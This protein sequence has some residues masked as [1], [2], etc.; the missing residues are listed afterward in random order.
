[1][2][3][4][5]PRTVYAVLGALLLF[6]FYHMTSGGEPKP[7]Q[8]GPFSGQVVD[9]ATGMPIPGAVLVVVWIREIPTPIHAGEQFFDARVGVAD[10]TGHFEIPPHPRPWF[11]G[12]SVN[13]P[14]LSCVAPGY[15][16]SHRYGARTTPV[17]VSLSPLTSEE[18][19][20]GGSID[21]TLEVIPRSL[22][23]E[24]Q[25]EIDRQRHKLQL[26]PIDF[27]SVELER[28]HR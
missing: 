6:V 24:L 7:G 11:F 25:R 18:Q 22:G 19:Q 13:E 20:R 15:G 9:A 8:W 10:A 21:Y 1:M 2:Q 14:V 12:N 28:V 16:H 4:V 26:P 27:Y 5:S 17:T 23:G 3:N